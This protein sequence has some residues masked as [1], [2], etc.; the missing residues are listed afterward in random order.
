[1]AMG[2]GLR[3]LWCL[4]AATLLIAAGIAIALYGR[5]GR[6]GRASI[7]LSA[8]SQ[9]RRD[10]ITIRCAVK[11][12]SSRAIRVDS[13]LAV[14]MHW[15]VQDENGEIVAPTHDRSIARDAEVASKD[16][17]IDVGPGN[18]YSREFSLTRGL[19]VFVYGH[20][21]TVVPGKGVTH[22]PTGFEEIA[23]FIIP[24]RS[25]KVTV[26]AAYKVD[27]ES[28]AAFRQWFGYDPDEAGIWR[29]E[30][31]SGEVSVDMID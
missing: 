16:R 12:N 19:R 9:Q 14:F 6:Q 1:M 3:Q 13:E 24:H 31:E 10:A 17:F 30:A 15:T 18:S 26:A 21:S 25:K 29:G 27:N 11:N 23:K 7:R 5:W 28:R 2:M 4:A 22:L 20:G 8:A